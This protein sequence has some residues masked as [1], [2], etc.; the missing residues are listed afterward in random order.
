[1]R[2]FF[3]TITSKAYWQF[4]LFSRTGAESV[5]AIFGGIYIVVE[6]LDF[7]R[8]YTRDEYASWAFIPFLSLS[9]IG[10]IVLR[11]PTKSVTVKMPGGDGAIEVRVADIFDV[12]G[13]VM[14]ST[15]TNFEADVA[16]GKIAPDSLQGQFTAKYFP[17]N[18]T[19]LIQ[20]IE[21]RKTTLEGDAPYP[22]GTTIPVTTH[23]KAF[24]FTAMA[25]LNEQGNASTTREYVKRALDGLWTHVRHSGELQ[26][27]GVP[28][29]GTGRGRLRI[30]RKTMI[31]IIAD[32]F[33][34]ASEDG[35]IT[36]HLVIAVP[37]SD[38][39]RFGVNLYDIKDY[40]NHLLHS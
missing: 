17:G 27:L 28:V 2:N 4:V 31:G 18:Q 40:L 6:V 26:E 13:A 36:D 34:K 24:Y 32:S 7:F 19:E 20:Q 39:D 30:S 14:V 3:R 22:I 1:M 37:P 9:I 11:P 15:N 8:I 29:V 21:Q 5:F 38:A 35:K 10:S 12:S 23:G 16:G 25:N 33:E